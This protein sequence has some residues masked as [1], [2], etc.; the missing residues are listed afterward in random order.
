MS[1]IVVTGSGRSGTGWC[2][3]IL[4]SAGIFSGHENVFTPLTARPLAYIDWYGYKADCSWLAVPRLPLMNVRAAL[5][6]R[7]PLDVVAS[8][9]HIGFGVEPHVNQF[10]HLAVTEG[11]MSPDLDG[12]LRFWVNWNRQAF[13]VCEAV[14]TLDQLLDNPMTLTRWA[15]AKREPCDVG[16]INARVEWKPADRPVVTWESFTDLEVVGQAQLMWDSLSVAA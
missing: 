13:P 3:A 15:G 12:Y 6:I 1:R 11:D 10:T 14:F 16:V 8:M 4:N 2:A 5:V 7:N 9:A